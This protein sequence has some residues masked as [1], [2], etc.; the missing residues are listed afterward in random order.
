MISIILPTYKDAPHLARAIESV[1]AQTRTDW[2]LIVV[3]DGLYTR[4]VIEHYV[5]E[6]S[7]ITCI[8][9]EHN[10]GI[11]R[12]LNAGLR[13]AKGEYIAR[14]DDDDAWTDRD[15]LAKQVAY[16][17]QHRDC[18]LVGTN[19]VIVDETGARLG[20]Y[21]LPQTDTLIRTRIL[22]KNCFLHPTIM[23][24]TDAVREVHGYSES[25]QTRH[26][27]DYALWLALGAYGTFANL[28]DTTT[29]LT[30][31][32]GSLT[33]QNRV[34]QVRHMRSIARQYRQVYPG[35]LWGQILL[36]IRIIGFVVI[37]VIPIPPRLLYAIQK[38]Y[39]EY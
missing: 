9:H 14:I 13:T 18:V 8:H 2:E 21:V 4:N 24:R 33:A 3:D 30:V 5:A 17:E 29:A 6:D 35:F 36:A 7:R 20:T 19:A 27:E 28:A 1:R 26:I 11:Q 22:S 16:L 10:L 23:M 39:K 25:P 12:S 15:K 34:T 32:P 37:G 38:V 31:R